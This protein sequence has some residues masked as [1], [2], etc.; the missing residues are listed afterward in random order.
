MEENLRTYQSLIEDAI[1]SA[2][3]LQETLDVRRGRIQCR[4]TIFQE[5]I[6]KAFPSPFELSYLAYINKREFREVHREKQISFA[7]LNQA[8]GGNGSLFYEENY[9]EE[10]ERLAVGWRFPDR[11]SVLKIPARSFARNWHKY[12]AA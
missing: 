3:K 7:R 11:F 4:E 9:A 12:S 6:I 1:K 8:T 5:N 10:L 2:D